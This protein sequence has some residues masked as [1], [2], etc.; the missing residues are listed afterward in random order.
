M[1]NNKL[2]VG[3][4]QGEKRDTR[5][6]IKKAKRKVSRKVVLKAQ[7]R[8]VSTLPKECWRKGLTLRQFQN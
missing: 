4:T 2:T 1:I 6:D 7:N 8:I 5:K 3:I